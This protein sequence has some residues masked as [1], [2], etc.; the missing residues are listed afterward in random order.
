MYSAI[1]YTL[2]SVLYINNFA[3][4]FDLYIN[5]TIIYQQKFNYNNQSYNFIILLR[6][7]KYNK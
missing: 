5:L 3:L 7:N 2:I 6:K 1:K 4:L